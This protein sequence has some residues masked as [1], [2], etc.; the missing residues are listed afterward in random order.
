MWIGTWGSGLLKISNLFLHSFKFIDGLKLGASA[1]DKY[2]NIWI[3]SNGGVWEV[4]K[5]VNNLWQRKFHSLL[6]N[7]K[8]LNI[9]LI[10]KKD[11]LWVKLNQKKGLQ[12]KIYTIKHIKNKASLMIDLELKKITDYLKGKDILTAYS[13]NQ[14]HLWFSIAKVGVALVNEINAQ[15]LKLY[16]PSD[17]IPGNDIKAFYQ[18]NKNQ[19]WIGGWQ[20]G[21][22]ILYSPDKGNSVPVFKERITTDNGLPDNMIRSIYEDTSGDI[23]IGTRHNGV[24]VFNKDR[25]IKQK[26][27]MNDG[28]LS[29]SIWG[30]VEGSENKICL[31]TDIGIEQIDHLTL[32]VLKPRKEFFANTRPLLTIGSYKNNIWFFNTDEELFIYDF[33]PLKNEIHY[34]LVDITKVLINGNT[35]PV[36]NFISSA[37]ESSDL[38]YT[39]NNITIEYAGLSFKDEQAVTYQYRLLVNNSYI[40]SQGEIDTNWTVPSNRRYVSFA[41]LQPGSY[42]FQVRAINIDGIKSKSSA[43]I[44]FNI[45]PPFWLRWWFILL[46]ALSAISM[47]FIFYKYRVNQLLKIE[48]LRTRIAA[49]LHD[50]LASNLSSI[51]MFGNIIQQSSISQEHHKKPSELLTRII[52]LSQES[53]TSIKEIIWAINPNIETVQSLLIKVRDSIVT[54]CKAKNIE[55]YFDIPDKQ[56]LPSLNLSPEIRRDLWMFLKESLSNSIKHS[57]CTMLKLQTSFDGK[58]LSLV[59]KD[60]GKGFDPSGNYEGNGLS[61]LKKRANNLNAGFKINSEIGK[62]TT[63]SIEMKI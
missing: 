41:S 60:D 33:I 20:E 54:N 6:S 45:I 13:D 22:S 42:L 61:N 4:Y 59:L 31:W 53:V 14:D 52:S 16:T 47:I 12:Y 18:D 51:A 46:I 1:M 35:I 5:D 29:N 25:T 2:G 26:L 27:T 21:I 30:I 50:E 37:E 39:E 49:D 63:L 17:S 56:L 3:G 38:S 43:S 15:L 44:I 24:V 11:R 9:L 32:K 62:G 48:K 8:N 28:L 10:D 40:F 55:L 34:P 19:V 57:G 23:W 58:L 36:T 7:D